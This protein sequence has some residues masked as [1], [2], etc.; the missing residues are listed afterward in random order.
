M[1]IL[2]AD[3]DPFVLEAVGILLRGSGLEVVN[4]CDGDEA[5][6]AFEERPFAV[7]LI[8]MVMPHRDGLE[9]I[10]ELR[11][12]WPATRIVAMSGG[13]RFLTKDNTLDW[14]ARLGADIT[15]A[16][17]FDVVAFSSFIEEQV[18]LA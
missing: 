8:D 10:M 17:P 15:L 14:A 11:R 18:R 4:A 12:R 3:D 2:V 5:I 6:A 1:R 7:A 9:T 16:K 13:S